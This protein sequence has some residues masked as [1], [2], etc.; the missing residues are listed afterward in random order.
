MSGGEREPE[1]GVQTALVEFV[2]DDE[3]DPLER[4]IV[5]QQARQHAFGDD[6]DARPRTDTRVEAH[7]IA[8]RFADGLA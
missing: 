6:L 4:R 3:P 8:D 1:I 2:E 5:L 7:A